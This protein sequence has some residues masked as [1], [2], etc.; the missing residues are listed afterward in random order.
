MKILFLTT[1]LPKKQRMGSEVASQC[2]IDA[3]EKLGHEV[4]TVG[5]MRIDDVFECDSKE[6]LI[7]KRYIETKRA[8]FYPLFWMTLS[9]LSNF[10]YSAAKYLSKAYV[11]TVKSLLS[12]QSYSL[13][14]VDH[15]QLEWVE[16]HL[17]SECKRF[18]I[19]HNVEHVIY[20]EICRSSQNPIAKWI[21]QR[22]A[23]LVKNME[24]RLAGN[25]Q[26]VWALTEKDA[27]YFSE[28]GTVLARAIALPPGL[29]DIIE[30]KV[31][32][33]FDIGIIGSWA[34]RANVEGLEWFLTHIYPH[35]PSS[36]TIHVAGKGADWLVGKYQNLTYRGFVPDAHE[37]MA[38][39]KV[40]A[41][42]TLS[43]SGI[44]IKTLDA[45]ASGSPIVATPVAVRGI[46]DLPATVQVVEQPEDFTQRL[47][48]FLSATHVDRQDS[49]EA[50]NWCRARQSKFLN[51]VSTAIS[52]V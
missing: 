20:Q 41:I 5:Y 22:E 10:P 3:L 51:D 1:V 31:T 35:L 15:A 38:Q 16:P 14:I 17:G 40:V 34:W 48:S 33:E 27:K 12:D 19:F 30:Q 36:C 6:I 46:S 2:F 26:E 49:Q 9:F 43:G 25:V 7:D 47:I 44:Q 11:R 29:A 4:T 28:T 18:A 24:D 50:L 8:K 23:N 37:F 32:K 42:P 13:A 45:I 39:A 52:Q 21:Y